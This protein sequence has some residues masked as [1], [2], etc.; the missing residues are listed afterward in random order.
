MANYSYLDHVIPPTGEVA[1]DTQKILFAVAVAGTFLLAGKVLSSRLKTSSGVESAIIPPRKVS[2]FSLVDLLVESFV[3]YN[4]SVMGKKNRRHVPFVA[5]IFFFIMTLNMLSLIPGMP[6]ATTTVW[7]NVAMALVVFIHFNYHGIKTHGFIGY[8]KHFWGP[9]A[10]LGPFLLMAEL[11]SLFI[12]IL[13]LNLR[14]F[15]NISADHLVLSTFVD[16]LP[17]FLAA[18]FYFLGLFV[19]FMQAFIFTTLTMIYIL[20][21]TEH[22]EHH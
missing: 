18:P 11:L 17:V 6:V 5:T 7:L 19:S 20:L 14:L 15:W 1:V 16:L 10:L 22:E 21:A 8:M 9:V 4:D 2:A 12:R 13:T 3:K